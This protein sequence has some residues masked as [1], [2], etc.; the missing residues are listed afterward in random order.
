MGLR[1]PLASVVDRAGAGRRCSARRSRA[2]PTPSGIATK[3]EDALAPMV[4]T[5]A[6]PILLLSGI[7][8]PMTLAPA[9]LQVVSAT[10][11]RS[12][13]SSMRCGRCSAASFTT[14]DR[15]DR[16][17]AGGGAGGARRL[18]GR[19]DV[20]RRRRSEPSAAALRGAARLRLSHHIFYYFFI[21]IFAHRA[22]S[23]APRTTSVALVSRGRRPDA[24]RSRLRRRCG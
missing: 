5:L 12:S 16:H 14:T 22:P 9:W 2:S 21:I 3:S 20:W 15:V 17:G 13:I 10:S 24:T 8:L 11:T 1:V 4:N 7:L 23:P 6:L 18:D 19:A